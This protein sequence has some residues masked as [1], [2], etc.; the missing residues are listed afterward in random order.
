MVAVSDQILNK[1]CPFYSEG[2]I[3][4]MFLKCSFFAKWRKLKEIKNSCVG[5]IN[6]SFVFG[7]LSLCHLVTYIFIYK[8]RKKSS[9]ALGIMLK[10]CI[11]EILN[12][13]DNVI[14]HYGMTILDTDI[15]RYK[16]QILYIFQA[17]SKRLRKLLIAEI[18]HW[19]FQNLIISI[20]KKKCSSNLW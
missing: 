11:S 19:S 20:S 12:Q 1:L 8:C 15:C 6:N 18:N 16:M 14:D 3:K 9:S 7:N 13:N 5:Q 17:S 4:D 2:W 10:S